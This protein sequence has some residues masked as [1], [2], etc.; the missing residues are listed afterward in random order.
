MYILEFWNISKRRVEAS[1]AH[2]YAILQSFVGAIVPYNN[3]TLF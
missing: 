3:M 2:L 1:I